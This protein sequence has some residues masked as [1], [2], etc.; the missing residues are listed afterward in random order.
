MTSQ[1]RRGKLKDRSP[2]AYM[3]KEIGIAIILIK[4]TI[5]DKNGAKESN[6]I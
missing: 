6:N 2:W 5:G 4:C 1:G 3:G